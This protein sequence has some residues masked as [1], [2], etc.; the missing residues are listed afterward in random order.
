M[1]DGNIANVIPLYN[2][3]LAEM[4][5]LAKPRKGH[6]VTYSWFSDT[7]II[8][9]YGA[10]DVDFAYVEQTGRLFFQKLILNHIPVRG[11]ITFGKLYSQSSRNIFVGPA[12]IDAYYYGEKQNWLGFVLTPKVTERLSGTSIETKSLAHY[13]LVEQQG[14]INHEPS[15]PVYAFSFNNAVVQGKNPYV[16]ALRLMQRRAPESEAGKYTNSIAFAEAH[17]RGI[18]Q[19]AK[20]A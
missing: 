12:L 6:G 14:I 11:A 2:T 9:S 15:K 18:L 4:E 8:Y 16:A 13:R 17:D 19:R 7:F 5:K 1:N 10:K 3:A 20:R